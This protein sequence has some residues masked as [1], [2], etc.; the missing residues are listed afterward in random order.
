MQWQYV[1]KMYLKCVQKL[2]KIRTYFGHHLDTFWICPNSVQNVSTKCP[3]I[4]TLF[5]MCM[6]F[7]CKNYCTLKKYRGMPEMNLSRTCSIHL[8]QKYLLWL[9]QLCWKINEVTLIAV[10]CSRY[11]LSNT[12]LS[13]FSWAIWY[14]PMTKDVSLLFGLPTGG[15]RVPVGN[16]ADNTAQPTDA[17]LLKMLGGNAMDSL[18]FWPKIFYS[19]IVK[20]ASTIPTASSLEPT[21]SD[22]IAAFINKNCKTVVFEWE[23]RRR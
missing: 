11:M 14:L 3:N 6:L 17:P 10:H 15:S 8:N 4:W 20:L 13:S 22:N 18:Q 5:G 1:S 16:W 12:T 7:A 21:R 23:L 9:T 19:G 2:S